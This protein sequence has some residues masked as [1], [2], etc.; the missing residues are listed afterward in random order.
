MPPDLRKA[1]PLNPSPELSL[2]NALVLI[3]LGVFL[4]LLINR[5]RG[6]RDAGPPSSHAPWMPGSLVSATVKATL[7]L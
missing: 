2:L 4:C 7:A 3:G 5:N 1:L 6:R